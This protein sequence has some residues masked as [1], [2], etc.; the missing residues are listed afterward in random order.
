MQIIT[1]MENK[2]NPLNSW[3]E[4]FWKRHLKV[5][6]F[7]QYFI[8]IFLDLLEDK[9]RSPD[10]GMILAGYYLTGANIALLGIYQSYAFCQNSYPNQFNAPT[11]LLMDKSLISKYSHYFYPLV[12]IGNIDRS[13][14]FLAI[15][16]ALFCA[17]DFV[18]VLVDV[19]FI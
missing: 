11:Y 10:L 17:Y 5:F 13:P 9:M 16:S 6:G 2:I 3:G 1:I 12:F 18:L 19:S 7:I 14:F 4:T 8:T 15:V